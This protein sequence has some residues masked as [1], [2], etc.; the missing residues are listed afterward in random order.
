MEQ[1]KHQNVRGI[2]N[3]GDQDACQNEDDA[4]QESI[5]ENELFVMDL[6]VLAETV[7]DATGRVGNEELL[8]CLQHST[9]HRLECYE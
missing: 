7:E 5:V 3:D 4:L 9:Q 2:D 1:K 8:V 6:H